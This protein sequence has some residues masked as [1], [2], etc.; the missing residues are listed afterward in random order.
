MSSVAVFQFLNP[1]EVNAASQ[2]PVSPAKRQG[3]QNAASR[4]GL[5]TQSDVR[6]KRGLTTVLL[7]CIYTAIVNKSFV[8]FFSSN[9]NY[10]YEYRK[11]VSKTLAPACGLFVDISI[12]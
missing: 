5:C 11:L 3:K 7:F 12:N 9:A 1:L 10:G 6:A 8:N 2:F 4:V